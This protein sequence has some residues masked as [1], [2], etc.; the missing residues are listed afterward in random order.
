MPQDPLVALSGPVPVRLGGTGLAGVG[1]PG[2][3]L[4]S[5]GVEAMWAAFNS[6][7]YATP[8]DWYIHTDGDPNA[9]GTASDPVAWSSVLQRL[10]TG[11][12]GPVGALTRFYFLNDQPGLTVF[13][14]MPWGG[15]I[16][17]IGTNGITT[18]ASSTITARTNLNV[19]GPTIGNITAGGLSG[20][21]TALGLNDQRIR[22]TSAA[23]QPGAIAWSLTDTGAK[24]TNVGTWMVPPAVGT[25]AFPTEVT[26]AVNDPFVVEH[27]PTFANLFLPYPSN[28]TLG[29]N[30]F[31]H[32]IAIDGAYPDGYASIGSGET[33][34]SF[35][36]CR[37]NCAG[38]GLTDSSLLSRYT[39]CGIGN[40]SVRGFA[41]IIGASMLPT[42]GFRIFGFP[43]SWTFMSG[44]CIADAWGL[45]SGYGIASIHRA[46]SFNAALALSANDALNANATLKGGSASLRI[47]VNDAGVP[48]TAAVWGNNNTLGTRVYGVGHYVA[49]TLTMTGS[50]S[51]TQVGATNKAI[52]ALPY[53]DMAADLVT[54]AITGTGSMLV[55]P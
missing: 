9:P 29:V 3:V 8:Q 49:G 35:T 22:L 12:I 24:S 27:L 32:D 21:W 40:M 20:T 37:I 47:G 38:G 23:S 2:T 51:D 45:W 5:T 19:A 4:M 28:P 10:G 16:Y 33:G 17:V 36:A 53:I 14:W 48:Y 25:Y 1:A 43:G 18:L 13:P 34:A 26:C 52:G 39:A 46:A 55:T 42:D 11:L 15:P 50:T 54:G 7:A 6:S 44:N 30:Y 41:E 31:F